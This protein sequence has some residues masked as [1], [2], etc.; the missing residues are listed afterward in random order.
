M[1]REGSFN[2]GSNVWTKRKSFIK[3]L[4]NNDSDSRV[5]GELLNFSTLNF[6]SDKEEIRRYRK[7]FTGV[8]KE[9][10]HAM[11][12]KNFFHE[13][14][15]FGIRLTFLGPN[16]CILEDLVSGE[17]EDFIADMKQWWE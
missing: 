13:E 4:R 14:G 10:K 11:N 5:E 17:V 2:H 8:I 12:L 9:S 16:L 6:F 7:V 15:L 3:V 1:R